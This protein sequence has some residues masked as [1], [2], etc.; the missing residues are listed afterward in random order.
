[1][2][3]FEF[4]QKSETA[5]FMAPIGIWLIPDRWLLNTRKMDV[6]HT[7]LQ[8]DLVLLTGVLNTTVKYFAERTPIS[9][10]LHQTPP[11]AHRLQALPVTRPAR[12][13]RHLSSGITAPSYCS[14][15]QHIA[16]AY[17]AERLLLPVVLDYS[18]Q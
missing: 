14:G 3:I 5:L 2:C 18:H 10:R 11:M 1:M 17:T 7:D 8:D 15:N 4:C 16:Y 12:N 13:A 6:L 9:N